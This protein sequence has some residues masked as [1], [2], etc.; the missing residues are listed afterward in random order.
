MAPKGNQVLGAS[1]RDNSSNRFKEAQSPSPQ[2]DSR[3]QIQGLWLEA[4]SLAGVVA[5]RREVS[6]FRYGV[7]CGFTIH[8][9]PNFGPVDNSNKL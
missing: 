8:C 7:A 4:L 9:D 6:V 3:S 1:G 2:S 5:S